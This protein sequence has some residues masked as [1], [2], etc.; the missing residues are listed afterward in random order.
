M[1]LRSDHLK[2][3][4]KHPGIV[5]LAGDAHLNFM[6]R[7]TVPARVANP[8][9]HDRIAHHVGVNERLRSPMIQS[10]AEDVPPR[11]AQ[12]VEGHFA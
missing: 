12:R 6:R 9:F 1:W 2:K 3:A 4:C 11:L 5:A 10:A 7:R 8:A